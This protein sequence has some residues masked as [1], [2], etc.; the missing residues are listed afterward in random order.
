M[1]VSAYP[2]SILVG[3][4]SRHFTLLSLFF[5]CIFVHYDFCEYCQLIDIVFS[6]TDSCISEINF[7][8]INADME[9]QEL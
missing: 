4:E 1:L 9:L 8:R 3:C 7:S 5:P 2:T 6:L